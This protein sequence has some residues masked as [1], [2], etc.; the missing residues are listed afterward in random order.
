M[1]LIYAFIVTPSLASPYLNMPIF[2]IHLEAITY[3]ESFK[4]FSTHY[5]FCI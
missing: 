1:S 3:S 4:L 5:E 2:T